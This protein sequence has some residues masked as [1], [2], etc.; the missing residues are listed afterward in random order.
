VTAVTTVTTEETG[1]TDSSGASAARA[2]STSA[3]DGWGPPDG[4]AARV[5]PALAIGR[6]AIRRPGE[7]EAAVIAAAVEVLWP[8]PVVVA[9]PPERHGAWRFSGRW[10]ARPATARRPRPW[11]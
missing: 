1:T 9:P 2:A 4:A 11:R 8:R 10:W 6:E 3:D 5:P 7:L